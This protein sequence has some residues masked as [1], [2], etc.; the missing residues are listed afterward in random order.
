MRYVKRIKGIFQD[1]SWLRISLIL[2]FL[3]ALP[4][5]HLVAGFVSFF[6]TLLPLSTTL[7]LPVFISKP[8]SLP[9]TTRTRLNLRNRN[10]HHFVL[11]PRLTSSLFCFT[12]PFVI[13]IHH[14]HHLN[15]TYHGL[16]SPLLL[17]SHIYVQQP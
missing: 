6:Y 12:T 9:S 13:S 5:F 14:S 10:L 15:A 17:L 7:A 1:I 8:W 3:Y 11:L 2:F 16:S 4:T